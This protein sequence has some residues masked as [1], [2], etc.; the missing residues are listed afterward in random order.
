MPIDLM[1][2]GFL[3]NPYP[4]YDRLRADKMRR[5]HLINGWWQVDFEGVQHVLRHPELY[6]ADARTSDGIGKQQ[7]KLAERARVLNLH[8]ESTESP[9]MLG[10]DPPDHS[11]LRRLVTRGF[12]TNLLAGL[13][14]FIETTAA[15]CVEQTDGDIF[16]VVGKLAEP[17]PALV[18]AEMLGV[19]PADQE[20]FRRWSSDMIANTGFTSKP[21]KQLPA[22]RAAYDLAQYFRKLIRERPLGLNNDDLIGRLLAAERDDVLDENEVISMSVLILIAGHETTTRLISNALYV[23]LKHPE[24]LAQLREAPDELL[25]NTIEEC[26][27]YESPVQTT[28][29]TVVSDHEFDGH[30]LRRG[31]T[32]LTF[33]GAANRDPQANANPNVFDIHRKPIKQISFGYGVHFCLGAALARLETK[34]ALRT[35]LQ[36]FPTIE[37]VDARPDWSMNPIFRGLDSLPVRI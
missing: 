13:T 5:S 18:I 32:I 25:D 26:L 37:L 27:R 1:G 36:R 31:Q 11:R 19:P 29:R 8:D 20:Q 24:Q 35:L 33:V 3:T 9:N 28:A 2:H 30:E 17:L 34:I 10:V 7:R 4:Y 16:E 21:D 6:T 22:M 23:L 15:A 14:P 12:T